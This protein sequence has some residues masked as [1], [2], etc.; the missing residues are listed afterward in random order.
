MALNNII[1]RV[2]AVLQVVSVNVA[3]FSTTSTTY[4]NVTSAA[5]SITPISTSSR[6]LLICSANG[7]QNFVAATNPTCFINVQ[8]NAVDIATTNTIGLYTVTSAGG[9]SMQGGI[10][11]S[12]IISPASVS[13]QSF[14]M[15]AR[16]SNASCTFALAGINLTVMEVI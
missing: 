4:V 16:T 12:S 13:A 6:L 3:S 1:N 2:N 15:T 8:R 10:N 14:Q 5:L 11:Y 9:N 7:F